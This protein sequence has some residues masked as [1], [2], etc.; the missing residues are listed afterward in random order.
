M[1]DRKVSSLTQIFHTVPSLYTMSEYE[2]M[3]AADI[4]AEA[5]IDWKVDTIFAAQMA[6]P[7]RQCVAFV[8]DGGFMIL[9]AEFATAV[10][11]NLP[12]KVIVPKN[13]I[14]EMIRWEQMAFLGNP[15]FGVKF[16]PIDFAR[17][18]EDCGGKGYVI[19]KRSELKSTLN[20]AMK[21]R[22]K[23]IIVEA[24]VDP[25]EPPMPPKLILK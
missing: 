9:M 25:F 17:F 15:E 14:L 20:Q 2:N 24:Y 5:L 21:E 8:G 11:Y 4:V 13:N 1:I 16:S 18:A 12:I 7:E 6:Y 3:R 10:Q 19:N 23:P 22:N